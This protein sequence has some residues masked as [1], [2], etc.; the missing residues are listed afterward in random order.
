M[1]QN[2]GYDTPK[3]GTLDWHIPLNKNFERLE[4]DVPVIDTED[5]LD[6]YVPH[7]GAMFIA[8]DT[9][10]RYVGD[11]SAW[12]ELPYPTTT[13]N[14]GSTSPTSSANVV[15]STN[16]GTVSATRDGTEFA[17]G[18]AENV[19]QS[20]MDSLVDGDHVLVESGSYVINTSKWRNELKDITWE[21]NGTITLDDNGSWQGWMFAFWS[22]ENVTFKGGT[23]DWDRP[24]NTDDGRYG[25]QF[26][27]SVKRST[28]VEI[29]GTTLLNAEDG[30]IGGNDATFVTIHHNQ[31]EN[32]GERGVYI[33]GTAS[34]IEVH[35]NVIKGVRSG[36]LRAN[37]APTRWYSHDN[38]IVMDPS[39][40]GPIYLFEGGTNH[41]RIEN[42]R[43][44]LKG[45]GEV[46]NMEWN[47]PNGELNR[48]VTITGGYYEG[49]PD[50]DAQYQKFADLRD[51]D[52]STV[53]VSA[54]TEIVDLPVAHPEIHE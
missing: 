52:L 13:S 21:S 26:I 46:L 27:L 44:I 34:D 10:R 25:T 45:T 43:G 37:D 28:N 33:S 32:S 49:S 22:C 7:S 8:T 29:T 11:G 3:E 2:H 53:T 24:N 5:T 39:N 17:S 51:T 1:T 47:G 40:Y 35:N 14:D 54:E 18:S 42:D 50:I 31:M 38:E 30:F 12:T 4:R 15:V 20:V 36:A 41:L 6:T 48:N 16:N 23:Y 9:G 19:F